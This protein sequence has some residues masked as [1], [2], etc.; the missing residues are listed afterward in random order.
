[1]SLS[2]TDI[3]AIRAEFP[4]L[5]TTVRGKPL[6]YLDNA[7][8]AQKPRAVIDALT[9]YYTTMNAN[10]HRGVHYLSETATTAYEQTRDK[11][12]KFLG[13]AHAHE[14]IFTR[15]ATEAINLVAQTYAR[16]TLQAGDE[17]LLT[18]M[19]HHSNLVPWQMVAKA[20]GATLRFIPV[21]SSG[22]LDLSQIDTL[23]HARTKIVAHTMLSNVL[24]TIT[25]VKELARRAHAVGAVSLV[26]ASQGAV[27][28][29]INVQDLDCDFLVCT[30][31]KL[32]G[33]T[34]VGLL[35]GKSALLRAMPPFLG[36]GEMISHVTWTDATWAD[37]PNK[38]EAGT[39]NIADVIAF[40]AALDFVE[41][42]GRDAIRAYE[43]QLT[44]Y[45]V[46]LLCKESDITIFGPG[47][48]ELRHSV[49]AFNVG[50]IHAHDMSQ[51]LDFE[52][53][54]VRAGHHCAQP[55]M[56]RL[57]VPATT[58]AS[59][60]FYNTAEEIERLIAGIQTARNFFVTIAGGRKR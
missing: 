30:G 53:I 44:H 8:T 28:L 38:F 49:I 50:S 20:T 13:A 55:L 47:L 48:G 3:A 32:Y 52:G 45:A 37:L 16:S 12:A 10:V 27:H 59:I 33:P 60:A 41:S 46:E 36:G 4:I 9:R 18:E 23:I 26:D 6:T 54:A 34:G 40:A 24:G 31:H 21:T 56:R 58:R 14:I 39:P 35:Y 25:P 2:P 57:G 15:N 17:I 29:P 11:V 51:T 22:V 42:V 5:Q 7:A 43:A 19:E 1:M